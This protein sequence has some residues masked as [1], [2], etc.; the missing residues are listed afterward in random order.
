VSST[1]SIYG[2]DRINLEEREGCHYWI[3]HPFA[4]TDIAVVDERLS[5]YPVAVFQPADRSPQQT[6]VVLGLQR[7]ATPPKRLPATG[8]VTFIFSWRP[9][10]LGGLFDSDYGNRAVVVAVVAVG[11]VQAAVDQVIDMVAVR[12]FFVAATLVLAVTRRRGT[13]VRV[14]RVHGQSVFVIMVIVRGVQTAIVQVIDVAVMLDAR[15]AAVLAVDVLMISVDF[16][17]HRTVLLQDRVADL[18][19]SPRS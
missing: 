9:W 15:V 12:H 17:A 2:P 6:P 5:G 8:T 19:G 3:H 10:R 18:I 14:R 4:F 7:L 1:P 16:V 13:M 11:M